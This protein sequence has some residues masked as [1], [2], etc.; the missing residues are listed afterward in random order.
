M[1]RR[2]IQR[3]FSLV[4][5]IVVVAIMALLAA[6]AGPELAAWIANSRVR[7][8]AEALQNDLRKAQAEALRRNHQVAF[9]LTE[10]QPVAANVAS[11]VANAAGRYWMLRVVSTT[12]QANAASIGGSYFV[13]GETIGRQLDVTVKATN[14]MLCFNTM[15]RLAANTANTIDGLALSCA[16]PGATAPA[17]FDISRTGADRPLRVTVSL[18]G[19][20]RMCDPSKTLS[21]T[22]PDGC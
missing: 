2:R 13:K 21:A 19:Q 6:L 14:A 15:G 20:V 16:V 10:T 1:L 7:S 3:G 11:V 22:K 4:E 12:E 9:V 18:A 17:Q 5:L 8:A